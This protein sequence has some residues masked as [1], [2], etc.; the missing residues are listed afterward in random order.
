[1]RPL[2]RLHSWIKNGINAHVDAFMC[3][4]F[5]DR[6]SNSAG[7]CVKNEIQTEF[8]FI[9]FPYNYHKLA[10]LVAFAKEMLINKISVLRFV[11]QGRGKGLSE[12]L[13]IKGSKVIWTIF[14]HFH[15]AA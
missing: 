15:A 9:P 13:L 3:H 6:G 14:P 11:P 2:N 7:Y 10:Q 12:L 5:S 4:L 8:H 1:M